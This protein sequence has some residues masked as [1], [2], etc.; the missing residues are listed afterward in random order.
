MSAVGARILRLPLPIRPSVRLRLTVIYGAVFAAAAAVL[1][2]VSYALVGTS[3]RSLPVNPGAYVRLARG[4]PSMAL[5][6]PFGGVIRGV[7][8]A[9][10]AGSLNRLELQYLL[11]FAATLVISAFLGWWMA[12]RV[13]QP[14]REITDTARRVSRDRL[15][16]RIA[17]A[18]PDDELRELADTFDGMLDRLQAAF[19]SQQR[20]IAN[21][22]HELRTPLTVIRAEVDVGLSDPAVTREELRCTREV[23]RRAVDRS[24][25]LLESLLMLARSEGGPAGDEPVPLDRRALECMDVLG[26]QLAAAGLTVRCDGLARAVARGEPELLERVVENLIE[27]AIRHNVAGGWIELSSWVQSGRAHLRVGNGGRVI[28]SE[29][30]TALVEPFR[31]LGTARTGS[32]AGLGLSIVRSVVELHGGELRL[33]APSSG[34][35]FAEVELPAVGHGRDPA[36]ATVGADADPDPRAR[37]RD[38]RRPGRSLGVGPRP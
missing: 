24:E 2:I 7:R 26:E 31:R 35:L 15:K 1:L 6:F 34:G 13:L 33:S 36:S 20:F 14:L 18:G 27:N 19:S 3:M 37:A 22:S 25:R 32:G 12:G 8:D 10:I 11:V 4:L 23:V 38:T 30:L 5:P 29:D 9:L 17:L 28:A 21:V 16:E